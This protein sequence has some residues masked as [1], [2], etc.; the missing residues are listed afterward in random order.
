MGPRAT[1][2]LRYRGG[3]S[4]SSRSSRSVSAASAERARPVCAS[5]RRAR[6]RW[7]PGKARR[8]I[9][10]STREGDAPAVAVVELVLQMLQTLEI[11]RSR[12]RVR[13][14]ESAWYSSNCSAARPPA[15]TLRT[16]NDRSSWGS[17]GTKPTRRFARARLPS[18]RSVA[19]GN[20]F[21]QRRLT[22]AVAGPIRSDALAA[23]RERVGMIDER[24][25]AESKRRTIECY[26]GHA[27]QFKPSKF[28]RS[29]P[30]NA[31]RQPYD[32]P[33]K[34][35]QVRLILVRRR[36]LANEHFSEGGACISMVTMA[37]GRVGRRIANV[38]DAAPADRGAFP[39]GRDDRRRCAARGATHDGVDWS[40]GCSSTTAAC[41]GGTIG[42]DIVAK[43]RPTAHPAHA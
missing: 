11:R 1:R 21:E 13:L 37:A 18:S 29:G 39:G 16:P 30:C 32:L 27:S 15:A 3:W 9:S 12:R 5:P 23:S 31:S 34:V 35:T 33:L 38:S 7:R 6:R 22:A 43:A 14:C 26:E 17:C 4:G 28:T 40:T 42:A 2:S 10:A 24:R 41:A 19:T 20:D 8:S 36:C 25:V